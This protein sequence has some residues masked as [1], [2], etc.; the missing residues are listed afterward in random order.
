[1][2]TAGFLKSKA[3]VDGYSGQHE[4]VKTVNPFGDSSNKMQRAL[5]QHD[6]DRNST[7]TLK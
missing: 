7:F 5:C 6:T 3:A 2:W 1:M 4:S